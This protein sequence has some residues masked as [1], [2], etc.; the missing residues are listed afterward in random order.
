MMD[1]KQKVIVGF[2][3]SLLFIALTVVFFLL[4]Q[5]QQSLNTSQEAIVAVQA[6]L[7]ELTLIVDELAGVTSTPVSSPVSSP[8]P[9]SSPSLKNRYRD[10]LY[11]FELTFPESWP[12]FQV[13]RQDN[14]SSGIKASYG[15]TF[16]GPFPAI[17]LYLTDKPF[18][19]QLLQHYPLK[20]R[21]SFAVANS[22]DGL[23]FYYEKNEG[24]FQCA[25]LSENDCLYRKQI[26]EVMKTLKKFT[27]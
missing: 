5:T 6:E 10:D 17:D 20:W 21:D 19:E 22:F 24:Y 25:Q 9:Q 18:E 4:W 7:Q 14:P 15:F 1:T 11:H 27:R 8:S 13:S 16:E 2:L 26:E 23:T 3:G 12:K